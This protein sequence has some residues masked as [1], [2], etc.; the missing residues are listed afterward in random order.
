MLFGRN[1][2][3]TYID[4]QFLCVKFYLFEDISVMKIGIDT[5]AAPAAKPI[6]NQA[7]CK[8]SVLLAKINIQHAT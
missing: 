6:I 4:W 3:I 8:Q 2:S 7:K 1:V 5:E